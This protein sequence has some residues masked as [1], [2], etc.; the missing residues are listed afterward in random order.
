MS[1][2]QPL[3]PAIEEQPG[4]TDSYFN[5]SEEI[6]A[7]HGDAVVVYAIFM[8]LRPVTLAGKMATDWL[9]RMV[10]ARGASVEIE[11]LHA[12]GAWVGGRAYVLHHRGYATFGRS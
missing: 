6:I 10:Q 3:G 2:H 4:L 11:A 12:E 9:E 7:K 1:V 8:R 5:I